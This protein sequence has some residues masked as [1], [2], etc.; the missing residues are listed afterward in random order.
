MSTYLRR[1]ISARVVDGTKE[2]LADGTVFSYRLSDVLPKYVL[3]LANGKYQNAYFAL[4]ASD[5]YVMPLPP[6]Y[7]T[8]QKL[9]VTIKATAVCKV[10]IVDPDLGTSTFLLKGS[11]GDTDGDHSGVLMWQG[12]VTSITIS[13]AAAGE[14]TEIDVFMF[15]IPDTEVAASWRTGSQAIGYVE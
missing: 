12:R 1:Q 15:E 14:T 6:E 10:V 5:S 9:S 2:S 7:D 13:V 4:D 11:S 3:K 8:T